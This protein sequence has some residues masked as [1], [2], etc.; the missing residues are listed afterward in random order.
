MPDESPIRH[1]LVLAGGGHSHV[2]VV[3]MLGMEKPNGLGISLVSE[4]A[5]TPYSGMLPGL[6]AGHY[7]EEECFI[8]LRRLCEWAGVRFIQANINGLDSTNSQLLLEGRPALGYNTLSINSGSTPAVDS[9]PGAANVGVALKPIKHFLAA[10]DAFTVSLPQRSEASITVV[11]GGAASVEVLLA[12]HYKLEQARLPCRIHFKLVCATDTILPSHNSRVRRALYRKLSQIGATVVTNTSVTSASPGELALSNGDTVATEFVAWAIH[13][14]PQSWYTEAGLACDE[15]GFIQ[16]NDYL[17]STSHNNVFAA[18]DCAAFATPLPKSGVYAVRQGPVLATNLRAATQDEPLKPYRPQR[19]FL[20]LLATGGKHAIASKGAMYAAGDWVWRW[21]N[22][23]DQDFMARFN[24]LPAMT[25]MTDSED[26]NMRCGGCGAK[27]GSQALARVLARIESGGYTCP[28]S[29]EDAATVKVPAGQQ[30]IQTVDFFRAFIDDPYLVGRIGANHCLGD[31][32]AMGAAPLS[33]Q[34][35]VTIPYAHD[36]VMEETLYQLMAGAMS[37]LEAENTP[38]LGGHSGEGAEL[39]FGL[40]VNG[41][42]APGTALPKQIPVGDYALLLTKP[43]GTGTLMAANMRAK[44]QGEWVSEALTVMAQ[45]NRQGADI[46]RAHGAVACTDITGFGLLGHLMEML[47]SRQGAS[48]DLGALPVLSGAES[49]LAEGLVSSLHSDNARLGECLENIQTHQTKPRLQLL[50]DPQTA[51][52][53]LGA[54]AHASA[55]DC[56]AQLIKAGYQA[57]II[58]ATGGNAGKVSLSGQG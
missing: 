19:S 55:K 43:L 58:G 16:V 36:K 4:S 40:T 46:L 5:I 9:I 38:L 53:L 17:Q 18:G 30:L 54:V 1:E 25:T 11:G 15:K 27:V 13:A 2:G 8:D 29:V 23:I 37:T 48:L 3:R 31:I 47:G 39:G 12:M 35:T 51:G 44:A 50:F 24:N 7:R 21:K 49:C 34:A 56:L 26:D 28:S 33:A 20:S 52:G 32:Y 10:F 45:S 57:A 42:L 41:T 14:G 6:I 22:R